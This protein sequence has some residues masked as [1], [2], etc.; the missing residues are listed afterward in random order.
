[1]KKEKKKRYYKASGFT[2]VEIMVVTILLAILTLLA[3]RMFDTQVTARAA[4]ASI[5]MRK[6]ADA[7]IDF[8]G[9]NGNFPNSISDLVKAGFYPR[10][11]V[12]PYGEKYYLD[13]NFVCCNILSGSDVKGEDSGEII[14]TIYNSVFLFDDFDDID[15]TQEKWSVSAIA[16]L[17]FDDAEPGKQR[18]GAV[19]SKNAVTLTSKDNFEGG[20]ITVKAY[21]PRRD[22]GGNIVSSSK[23]KIAWGANVRLSWETK[24]NQAQADIIA[25]SGPVDP[26]VK[27]FI[28]NNNQHIFKIKTSGSAGQSASTMNI[29]YYIDD[30]RQPLPPIT[31]QTVSVTAKPII[32]TLSKDSYLDSVEA[33][34]GE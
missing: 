23:I 32:I 1:M 24:E 2:L 7:C 5:E 25:G 10:V 19:Y 9:T 30:M 34:F 21:L 8:N 22:L 18:F 33:S 15:F 26:N 31:G 28:P 12:S 13:G 6:L 3:L 17:E 4:K 27:K 29:R 20:V 16:N 14:R 11:P